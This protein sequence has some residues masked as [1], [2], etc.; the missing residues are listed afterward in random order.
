M[1][2]MLLVFHGS[3]LYPETIIS[4]INPEEEFLSK[5]AETLRYVSLSM[6]IFAF[7]SVYFQTINGYGK[8]QITFIIEVIAVFLYALSAYLFIK[9][10]KWDIV[11]VWSVEYV[12]FCTMGL[13]SVAY[14]RFRKSN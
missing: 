3:F 12:Y 10:W 7:F 11:Y 14:L 4:W 6:F 2:F 8:T 9:V 5:S 13:L 1:I